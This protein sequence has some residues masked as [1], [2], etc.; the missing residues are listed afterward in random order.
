MKVAIM[1]SGPAGLS[2]AHELEIHGIKPVIYERNAFIGEPFSHVTAILPISHKPI[3]DSVEYFKNLNIDITPLNAIK[4]LIHHSPNK[5]NTVKGSMGYLFKYN[6]DNDSVKGQMYSKLKNTEIIFNTHGDYKTL[7]EKYDYVVA[8]NGISTFAEEL[9]CWQ[10]WFKAS[11][12]GAVVLGDFDPNALIM[13]INRDYCKNGYAYLT[14]F[15]SKKA[16]LI[17]I[18]PDVNVQEVDHYWELFLYSEN[19]KYTIVEEFKLEH[20]SGHVYPHRVNN[21]FLA[22]N[23]GGGLDPFLGFGLINS[24]TMGVAA[25]RDNCYGVKTMKSR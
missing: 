24:I 13:W 17:I 11:A 7:S 8:A 15:N 12:R 14:P 20:K 25:A 4:S 9:G 5:T 10:E 18:V 19:L 6:K 16:S 21:I 23:A 2:C 1:G 22:G 3:K